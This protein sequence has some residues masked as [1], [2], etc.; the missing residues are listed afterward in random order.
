MPLELGNALSHEREPVDDP[1]I[2][3]QA[4]EAIY[5]IALQVKF[6]SIY[7]PEFA[8]AF[9]YRKLTVFILNFDLDVGTLYSP[10]FSYSF[11]NSWKL[12][13]SYKKKR[14][15]KKNNQVFLL[16]MII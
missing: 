13:I 14:K 11:T 12:Q 15:R 2:R 7:L 9:F 4:L 3:V 1:E 6:T 5:L 8:Q 16:N 10:S